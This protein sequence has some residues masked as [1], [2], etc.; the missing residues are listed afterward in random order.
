[1]TVAE[2]FAAE[3]A[4]GTEPELLPERLARA[5]VA[6]LPVDGAGLSHS[7]APGRRLPLGAG[8]T[9]ASVAERLQFA[10][11]DGPCLEAQRRRRP[12]SA[13]AAEL[14]DRWPVYAAQLQD[15][16]PYRSVLALPV[17]GPLAAVTML[18]LFATTPE[19]PDV[20]AGDLTATAELVGEVLAE[21]MSG[22]RYLVLGL[23]E[24]FHQPAVLARQRIWLAIGQLS[25]LTGTTNTA[26]LAV[27]RARAFRLDLDLETAA[28]RYLAGALSQD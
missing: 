16:T 1:M 12:L 13:S 4:R 23:P 10:L 5:C 6:A 3:L 14:G 7:F 26:A 18:V 19:V 24:W 17:G 25:T 2:A 27:L 11:G 28:D 20:P 9:D 21:A 8:D 22:G 15:R